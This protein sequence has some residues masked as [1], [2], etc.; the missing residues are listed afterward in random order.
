MDRIAPNTEHEVFKAFA[1]PDQDA[2][3]GELKKLKWRVKADKGNMD[4]SIIQQA[5]SD[6]GHDPDNTV[7]VMCSKDGDFASLIQEMRD[8]G[9]DVY[10]FGP[11]D[12]S[13]KLKSAVAYGRHVQMPSRFANVVQSVSISGLAN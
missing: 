8:W 10:L 6:C 13:Q 1:R 3:A 4:P 11:S 2:A 7:L 5:K 9:V 12:T